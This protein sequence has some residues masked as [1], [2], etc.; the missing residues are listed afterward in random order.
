MASDPERLRKQAQSISSASKDQ[1][2]AWKGLREWAS[3][4]GH[5]AMDIAVH[6]FLTTYGRDPSAASLMPDVMHGMN[7]LPLEEHAGLPR[8]RESGLSPS[9]SMSPKSNLALTKE[10]PVAIRP[11]SI[12]KPPDPTSMRDMPMRMHEEMKRSIRLPLR[13]DEQRKPGS[14]EVRAMAAGKAGHHI[15]HSLIRHVS[16]HGRSDAPKRR[17]PKAK[18]KAAT[19]PKKKATKKTAAKPK[20]KPQKR[21]AKPKKPK[22]APKMKA[23]HP[24]KKSRPKPKPAKKKPKARRRPKPKK[25]PPKKRPVKRKQKRRKTRKR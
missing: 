10:R 21:K 3:E 23:N 22:P 11:I 1:K 4:R 14:S 12:M 24:P 9:L 15:L 7:A 13:Q 2:E 19:A 25:A 16:S 18:P 17:K 8:K 5:M 20:A 6:E